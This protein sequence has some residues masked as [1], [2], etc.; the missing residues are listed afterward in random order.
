MA[1][2]CIEKKGSTVGGVR[3]RLDW[4]DE[5]YNDRDEPPTEND[6]GYHV[7]DWVGY[8]TGKNDLGYKVVLPFQWHHVNPFNQIVLPIQPRWISVEIEFWQPHN[9]INKVDNVVLT[10]KCV[11]EPSS[12]VALLLGI[13]SAAPVATRLRSK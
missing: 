2:I 1:D 7:S 8:M 10:S 6:P 13:F 9:V 4:W 11:P 3:F 5:S 12:F